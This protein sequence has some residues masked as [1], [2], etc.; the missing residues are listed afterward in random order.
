MPTVAQHVTPNTNQENVSPSVSLENVRK[1]ACNAM[2]E[3]IDGTAKESRKRDRR[4]RFSDAEKVE[5]VFSSID[6]AKAALLLVDKVVLYLSSASNSGNALAVDALKLAS[7]AGRKQ[8]EQIRWAM[9]NTKSKPLAAA[10]H[11]KLTKVAKQF[12]ADQ[13]LQRR[14]LCSTNPRKML[15]LEIS[16]TKHKLQALPEADSIEPGPDFT[17]VVAP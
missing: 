9:S 2:A 12:A 10:A 13:Q 3:H 7:S 14:T 15:H 1:A 5:L 17:L 4:E 6:R 16:N 11:G 8:F